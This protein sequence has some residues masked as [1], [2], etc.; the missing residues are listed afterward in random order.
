MDEAVHVQTK[1]NDNLVCEAERPYGLAC[2]DCIP[3]AVSLFEA[4]LWA[5]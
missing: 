2:C 4:I 3:S 1:V 5:C